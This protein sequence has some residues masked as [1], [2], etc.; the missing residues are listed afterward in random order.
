MV[1]TAS[2]RQR[3][4]YSRHCDTV[5]HDGGGSCKPR[6][7]VAQLRYPKALLTRPWSK[8]SQPTGRF[9]PVAGCKLTAP[10]SLKRVSLSE[11]HFRFEFELSRARPV[12]CVVCV[13]AYCSWQRPVATV[14]DQKIHTL[15]SSGDK[16]TAANSMVL[17]GSSSSASQPDAEED[18]NLDLTQAEDREVFYGRYSLTIV[19]MQHYAGVIHAHEYVN[20]IREPH[21]PYDRNAIRVVNMAGIQVELTATLTIVSAALNCQDGVAVF[22]ACAA[23]LYHPVHCIVLCR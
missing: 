5:C 16:F 23:L 7:K 8:R 13:C 4:R 6:H 12:S 20:F 2:D 14:V 19:G 18:E 10:C 21:N 15:M 22:I 9:Q 1:F 11:G 3:D 17:P